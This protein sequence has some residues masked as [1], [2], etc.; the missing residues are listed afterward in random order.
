MVYQH[1][2][3]MFSLNPPFVGQ[4]AKAV[5]GKKSGYASI[6]TKMRE[7]GIEGREDKQKFETV[8]QRVKQLGTSKRGLVTDHEF[9][10]IVK[11]VLG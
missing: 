2:L 1:P 3:A 10:G 9:R 8:L 5:L 6:T 4:Q 11:E 7:L